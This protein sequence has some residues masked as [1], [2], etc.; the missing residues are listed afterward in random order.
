MPDVPI[1]EPPSLPPDFGAR[2]RAGAAYVNLGL[3]KFAA[4]LDVPGASYSTLRAYVEQEE[5]PPPLARA[6]LV[7]RLSEA[8]GLSEAFFLGT[9]PNGDRLSE[10]LEEMKAM[11][12]ET[13]ARDA[14]MRQLLEDK[15]PPTGESQ[16]RRRA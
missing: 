11:R 5:R 13:A 15:L 2:I 16:L 3:K 1:T 8:T 6:A 12:T 4:R 14:A 7:R 9:E 10:L